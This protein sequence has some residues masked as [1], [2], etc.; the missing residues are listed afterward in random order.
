MATGL[1]GHRLSRDSGR[2]PGWKER[3]VRASSWVHLLVQ[4]LLGGAVF[5]VVTLVFGAF[6]SIAAWS[7]GTLTFVALYGAVFAV[8]TPA[9]SHR[10]RSRRGSEPTGS[11]QR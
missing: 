11:A 1:V 2:V 6:E 3:L 10:T 9:G 5:G 4:A 7:L 8:T